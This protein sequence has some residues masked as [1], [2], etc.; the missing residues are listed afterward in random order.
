MFPI[1]LRTRILLWLWGLLL[2]GFIPA[3]FFLAQTVK[4]DFLA[5][6]E[7]RARHLLDATCWLFSGQSE[8]LDQSSRQAWITDLGSRLGARLTLIQNGLVLA[9]SH[10]PEQLLAQVEDHSARPEVLAARQGRIGLDIRRSATIG[11][12]MIYAA[13]LCPTDGLPHGVLRLSLPLSEFYDRLDALQARFMALLAACLAASLALSLLLTR[14]M[15]SSIRKMISLVSNVGRGAYD[16]RVDVEQGNEFAPLAEA[17]N[18]M[19]AEISSQI[20]T[21]REQK[22]QLEALFN[23]LN[24]GV[25]TVDQEGRILS[26]N[27]AFKRFFPIVTR[28]EGKTILEGTLEPNLSTA[29]QRVL[30]TRQDKE[31]C[32]LL[33]RPGGRELEARINIYQ[34]SSGGLRCVVMIQDASLPKRMEKIRRDFVANVSHQ[35]RTPLTS[36]KGYVETLLGAPPPEA[37]TAR[38]FLKIIHK[39]A[40]HMA[41]MVTD[42]LKLAKL[43]SQ[44]PAEPLSVV[45]ARHALEAAMEICSPLAASKNLRFENQLVGENSRI[46]ADKQQIMQVFQNIIENAIRFSP[47]KGVITI[48]ARPQGE[49]IVFSV[50][51]QGPGVPREH[52]DRLFERFYRSEFN[53]GT[54]LGLAI[55]KHIIRNHGG[56][57]W[58]ESIPGE[59]A[60]FLF[61][62]KAAPK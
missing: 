52:Q 9:D 57:I 8:L 16:Q 15:L 7:D 3:Y 44:A 53:G 31:E 62:I 59:G 19:A 54:G 11:H 20:S 5:Y 33:A 61:T 43:E 55:C 26:A 22:T 14:N 2:A 47:P 23:G 58:V 21:I 28:M 4:T 60:T 56:R 25:L 18:A 17:V 40:E 42:L 49:F 41:N 48:A 1:S 30:Y 45:D 39:N 46:I 10:I 38:A 51:D 35:L 24:E 50:A 6:G 34:D 13:K 37:E 29:V 36:I 27:P 32:L 12:D